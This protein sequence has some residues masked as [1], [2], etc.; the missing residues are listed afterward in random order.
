[1]GAAGAETPARRYFHSGA[2]DRDDRRRSGAGG[3]A[4]TRLDALFAMLVFAVALA[5]TAVAAPATTRTPARSLLGSRNLW[6]TVN[7]CGP[8]KQ[9]NTI[10]IRGSMP[11]DGESGDRMFMSFRLQEQSAATGRW[12]NLGPAG[13]Y[14]AVGNGEMTR[15]SGTSFEVRSG[16]GRPSLVLRGLVS[17]QWRHAGHVVA[18]AERLTSRGHES[19]AGADPPHYTAATCT[20]G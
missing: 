6:A 4:A 13:E 3:A 20:I 18:Q 15:Q 16:R 11:G 8:A 5:G 10:G 17:F 14:Q 1:M 19:L 2:M 7:V 9:R 12:R